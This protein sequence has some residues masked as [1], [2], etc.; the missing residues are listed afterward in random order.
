[1]LAEAIQSAP[2]SDMLAFAASRIPLRAERADTFAAA[3]NDCVN[4]HLG[5]EPSRIARKSA[6][7]PKG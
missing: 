6:A 4:D 2:F 3:M 7:W 1:M 5:A